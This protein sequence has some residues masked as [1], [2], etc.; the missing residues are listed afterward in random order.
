MVLLNWIRLHRLRDNFT[1][2]PRCA[3]RQIACCTSASF[4]EA[5]I[6]QEISAQSVAHL[7][8]AAT[9]TPFGDGG[10]WLSVDDY[11]VYFVPIAAIA[12]VDVIYS[13]GNYRDALS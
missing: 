9:R 1:T 2:I 12:L 3:N 8:T 6:C 7:S 11:A 10:V 13:P 4:P 5:F